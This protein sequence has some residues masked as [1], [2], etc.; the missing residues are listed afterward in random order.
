MEIETSNL[1]SSSREVFER[2]SRKLRVA[3]DV[4]DNNLKERSHWV[5]YLDPTYKGNN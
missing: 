1:S 4:D 2:L 5:G 3:N